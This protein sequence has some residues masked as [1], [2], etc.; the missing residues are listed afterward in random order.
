MD[1]TTTL[2][3]LE[4]ILEAH[5]H[6]MQKIKTAIYNSEIEDLEIFSKTECKLARWLHTKD[7]FMRDIL[8]SLFFDNI[9][10]IHTRWHSEYTVIYEI[11]INKDEKK[12]LFSKILQR[13]SISAM[14]LD[15]VKLYYSGLET[16]TKMLLKALESAQRRLGALPES[17][18]VK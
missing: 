12:G 18:F 2:K 9:D 16:T 13:P 14:E 6:Q 5:K 11:L 8:G 17:M 1:K 4:A 7:G 3:S 15:K 10:K